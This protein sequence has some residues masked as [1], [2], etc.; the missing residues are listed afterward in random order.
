[1]REIKPRYVAVVEKP[2]NVSRDFVV[3]LNRMSREVDEDIYVDFLWGIITGIDA[4][5]GFTFGGESRDF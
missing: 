2:E 1:M 4:G 5:C 3:D